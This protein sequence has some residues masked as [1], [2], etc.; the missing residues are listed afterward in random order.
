VGKIGWFG[1][2][3]ATCF[4]NGISNRPADRCLGRRRLDGEEITTE[5][6]RL[7]ARRILDQQRKE[8]QDREKEERATIPQQQPSPAPISTETPSKS[9]D[10]ATLASIVLIPGASRSGG[11]A[12]NELHL[13]AG[14]EKVRLTLVVEDTNYETFQ[15]V[16]Q[17]IERKTSWRRSAKL[18]KNSSRLT[19]ELPVTM[20]QPDDYMIKVEGMTSNGTLEPVSDYTLRVRRK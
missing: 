15:V 13:G 19:L 3:S 1:L 9:I 20:L 16:A 5:T 6:Q 17:G 12:N 8:A 14:I 18:V 4:Q 7:E 10:T 11:G 2:I